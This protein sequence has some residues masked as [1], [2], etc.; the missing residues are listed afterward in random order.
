M[1]PSQDEIGGHV[2]TILS[3][4]KDTQ[5]WTREKPS[6]VQYHHRHVFTLSDGGTVMV[7]L[8]IQDSAKI[9]DAPND[10]LFIF[11]GVEGCDQSIYVH[12]FIEE[13]FN[14]RNYDVCVIGYRG[15]SGL[16]LTTPKVFNAL[17]IEDIREPMEWVI[18]NYCSK[19]PA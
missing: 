10:M 16:K 19:K 12:N 15:T 14:N 8:K 9:Q 1:V 3:T 17:C 18:H 2:Q 4:A 6:Y 11:P 13:A 5:Y 7:S